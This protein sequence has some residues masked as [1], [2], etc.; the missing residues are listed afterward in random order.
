MNKVKDLVVTRALLLCVLVILGVSGLSAQVSQTGED[1]LAPA[2]P[3]LWTVGGLDAGNTGAGQASRMAV[4]SAGN[5]AVISSYASI[6]LLNVT[7]YTPSGTQRW[8]SSITPGS[9]TFAADWV[10]AAPN[11]DI[12]ALAAKMSSSSGNLFG[13]TVARFGADGTFKWRVDSTTNVLSI[14]RLCVDAT[15]NVY[16]NYNSTLYKY[17]PDGVQLWSTYTGL[18]DYAAALT[19]DGAD[20]ILTG[21][22]GGFWRTGSF[23]TTTG[24]A[25][26]RAE[27]MEGTAATDL[28]V[29]NDRIYIAGQG[30]TGVGTPAITQWL[31]VIAYNRTTGARLWRTDKKPAGAVGPAGPGWI[32]K[33]PDGTLH[34]T[35]PASRGFQDWYTVALNPNGSVIWDAVR[36][37][38]LNTDEV[39]RSLTVLSNGTTVVTGVGGP[40]LPGGFI[41]GVTAGYDSNGV[42][43]WE[44]F[45]RQATVWVVPIQNGDICASGGYD[46]LVTCFDVPGGVTPTLPVAS[47]VATPTSGLAPIAVSF[48]GRGSSGPHPIASWAWNFGDGSTGVGSQATH[49]YSTPGSYTASLVVTDTLGSASTPK[50]VTITATAPSAPPSAPMGLSATTRLRNSVVLS[51]TNTSTDQTS[52]LIERCKGQ[53]CFNFVQVAMVAGTDSTYT[54]TGLLAN[55]YYRYRIRS[56][57]GSGNSGY[58]RS[59][60]VRT[61]KR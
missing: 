19:P 53:M 49:V 22:G 24:A 13:V 50:T 52:V 3:V 2:L 55:T 47:I 54:D 14:G 42:L 34:V 41:Q 43:I 11:G 9:G 30:Q 59:V 57:N 5:I 44:A 35:G 8:R 48:D 33:A 15:G 4:D 6:G 10:V 61:T 27:A 21:A 56:S 17:S 36:D 23:N 12:I 32:A 31:T 51:W 16:F 37:G 29:D 25:G 20:I 60:T 1:L 18:L 38:G 28:V 39:P 7:S 26:W 58:T 46:A 40:N 45:S